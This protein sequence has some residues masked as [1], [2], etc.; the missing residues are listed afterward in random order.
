MSAFSGMRSSSRRPPSVSYQLPGPTSA[1][2]GSKV[3]PKP[4]A[5]DLAAALA[6]LG[7]RDD[8]LLATAE[9]VRAWSE[10]SSAAGGP[11]RLLDVRRID[12]FLGREVMAAR[13]GRIPGARHRVFS[14]WVG[15]D[16]RMRPAQ[17]ALGAEISIA[18]PAFS[19]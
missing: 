1:I 6:R 18:V 3:E 5:T 12:E 14:E 11:T 15:P 10:E 13:G 19:A 8:S 7:D 17:D 2:F 4:E 9:Q 16:G